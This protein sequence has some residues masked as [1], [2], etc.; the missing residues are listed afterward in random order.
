M[1]EARDRPPPGFCRFRLPAFHFRLARN[2][3][4]KLYAAVDAAWESSR[5]PVSTNVLTR[6]LE[7]IV[8][9]SPP[10][11]IQGRRI[12]LRYA[13]LGGHNPLQIVIHGKQVEKLP[14]HYR[15]Y[16]QNSFRAALELEGATVRIELRGDANPYAR[17]EQKLG[18][19]QLARKRRLQR[20]RGKN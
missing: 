20:H 3:V 19:R 8:A 5:K 2:R 7:Q 1:A 15:R 9:E 11:L 10:P 4:G 16:L 12:K 6:M 14:G 13:H 18:P 17:D